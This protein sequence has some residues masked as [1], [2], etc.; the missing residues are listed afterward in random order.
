M[1]NAIKRLGDAEF[2]IMQIIWSSKQPV[3]SNYV[4]AHLTG[5]AWA[6]STLMTVLARLADKGFIT[7]D[8][9]TRTN[10]YSAALPE[11][12]Y[13]EYESRLF[14]EKVHQNS[15]RNLVASLYDGRTIDADD[16]KELRRYLNSLGDKRDE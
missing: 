3:P 12:E 7:C 16:I 15:L 9:S 4:M 5:R 11:Q 10:Y 2:E 6:L 8:R 1:D 13:K 14:L